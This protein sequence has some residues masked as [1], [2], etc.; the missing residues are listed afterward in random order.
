MT[1][2][3]AIRGTYTALAGVDDIDL[4]TYGLDASVSKGFGPIT[5]YGG[6]GQVW[7]QAS[8]NVNDNTLKYDDVS[9]SATR[10]FV[11]TRISLLIMSIALQADFSD[12]NMYSARASIS[13]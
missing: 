12:I 13:F 2:A 7:I 9:T 11:G 5:P 1:P 10:L 3:V 8:E 6:I 4:S